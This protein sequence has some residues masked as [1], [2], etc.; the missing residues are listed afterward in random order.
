MPQMLENANHESMICIHKSSWQWE[1]KQSEGMAICD[2]RIAL[3]TCGPLQDRA[4]PLFKRVRGCRVPGELSYRWE[5]II[6]DD[7]DVKATCDVPIPA[8]IQVRVRDDNRSDRSRDDRNER[9]HRPAKRPHSGPAP[10]TGWGFVPM[11]YMTMENLCF[12]WMAA[13]QPEISQ[14]SPC[15]SNAGHQCPWQ[16]FVD[17][18]T[19][20]SDIVGFTEWC[21]RRPQPQQPNQQ[22]GYSR[23]GNVNRRRGRGRPPP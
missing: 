17:P 23:R 20:Q 8:P 3:Y 6:S 11:R 1:Q 16:H 4:L 9:E 22:G 10:G 21:R 12:E 13:G 7:R 15:P 19:P 18:A 2:S 14:N 5:M